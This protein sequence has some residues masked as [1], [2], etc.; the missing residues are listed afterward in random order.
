M[1]GTGVFSPT[2]LL[3]PWSPCGLVGSVCKASPLSACSAWACVKVWE[4]R[5]WGAGSRLS[6]AQNPCKRSPACESSW[7][8]SPTQLKS[9]RASTGEL[10]VAYRHKEDKAEL[11]AIIVRHNSVQTYSNLRTPPST[12]VGILQTKLLYNT[13]VLIFTWWEMALFIWSTHPHPLCI[14]CKTK[15][16]E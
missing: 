9:H 1:P 10:S 6:V 3:N 16:H 15:A 11:L 12:A 4:G 14:P 8:R 5:C 7:S 2:Y 13:M